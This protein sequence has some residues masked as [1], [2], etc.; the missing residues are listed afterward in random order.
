MKAVIMAGGQGT[1]FWPLS[2]EE[3]PKQFLKISGPGTMLQ[4][5]VRRL[6]PLIPVED[7]YVVCSA[8]YAGLVRDQLPGLAPDQLVLEPMPR[9]TAPCIGLAALHLRRK[10]GNEVMAVLPSD[11]CIR[12]VKEFQAALRAAEQMAR[13]GWLVTFGIE[14][15]YPAT[16]Y[17]YLQ[18][19]EEIGGASGKSAFRVAR[20]AEKPPEEEARRFVERGDYYWNSGMFVWSTDRILAEIETHMPDLGGILSAIE[21][22]WTNQEDVRSL[23]GGAPKT[24]I[25]YGVME[26]A[27]KVAV[28]PCRLGWS[29][30]GNWKALRD[31]WC[32][33]PSGNYSNAAYVAH[34]VDD[35]ILYSSA[36]HLICAVGVRGLVVVQTPDVTLVCPQERVEDVKKL[37]EELRAREMKEYL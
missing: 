14:P 36:D 21:S 10:F 16:G 2:R 11:H 13:S 22:R 18:R 33:D 24:S 25:D 26:R 7:V 12:D 15:Q 1:R 5:T 28:L 35:C 29:D 9:N 3:R 6:S 20:F 34:D 4:E 30:V 19:G 27:E 23:F 37:V 32:S 17:G 31:I 8:V